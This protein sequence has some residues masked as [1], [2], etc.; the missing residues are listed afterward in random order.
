MERKNSDQTNKQERD[1]YQPYKQDHVFLGTVNKDNWPIRREYFSHMTI[2]M[3]KWTFTSPQNFFPSFKH[4][5]Y[6]Q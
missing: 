3:Q 5:S 6:I 4:V 2:I 1:R